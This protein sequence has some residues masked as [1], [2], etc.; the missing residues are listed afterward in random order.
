[1][2]ER[3]TGEEFADRPELV[4]KRAINIALRRLSVFAGIVA[5]MTLLI[6]D[7]LA[8]N[9]GNQARQRIADCTTPGGVCFEE[10]Q[11]RTAEAVRVLVEQGRQREQDTQL[12]VRLAA[13]CADQPGSQSAEQIRVCIEERL[14]AR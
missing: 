2:N 7:V 13:A 8:T 14:V 10:A 5:F 9:A 11:K 1:M 4:R 6:L 12:I 3:E